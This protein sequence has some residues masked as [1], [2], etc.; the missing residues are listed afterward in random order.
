MCDECRYLTPPEY[1]KRLGVDPERVRA[2]IRKGTLRAVN[3]GDGT[4][5][6]RFRISPDAIREFEEKRSGKEPEAPPRRK[7]REYRFFKRY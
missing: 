4:R 1:A 7:P 2:W 3:V 6:S 5:R